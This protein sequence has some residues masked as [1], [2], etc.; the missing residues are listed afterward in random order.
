MLGFQKTRTGVYIGTKSITAVEAACDGKVL[1]LK[2]HFAVPIEGGISLAS[3]KGSF[4]RMLAASGIKAGKVSVSI[5]DTLV[6]TAFMDIKEL[7]Q[8]KDEVY[9]LIRWKAAKGFNLSPKELRVGYQVFN[10]NGKISVLVAAMNENLALMYEDALS[11][12][13]MAVERM[14]IHSFN[15]DNLLAQTVDLSGNFLVVSVMDEFLSVRIFKSGILDFYRRKTVQG[16]EDDIA[17]ELAA[18]FLSYRGKNPDIALNKIYFLDGHDVIEK[19]IC[20]ISFAQA[21][22]IKT[23]SMVTLNGVSLS[24]GTDLSGLFAALGAGI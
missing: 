12:V 5:P 18:S 11:A 6:N 10:D 9:E 13:G 22:R 21:E 23:E 7:P 2:K 19:A 1:R 15:I 20:K 3:L 4:N 17:R 14:N 8:D 16:R 24:H